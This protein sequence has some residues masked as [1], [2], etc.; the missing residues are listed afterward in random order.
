MATSIADLDLRQARAAE[1]TRLAI[2]PTIYRAPK[3]EFPKTAAET[4]GETAGETRVLGGVLGKLL[5]RLPKSA[6]SLLVKGRG[7][8][9]SSSPSTPPS[10]RVSPAVSPAVSAAVL[11]NSGLGRGN[12]NTRR[13]KPQE[14]TLGTVGISVRATEPKSPNTPSRPKFLQKTSLL[15]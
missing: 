9:R 4:A 1:G 11:G 3:P 2:P 5:R 6:V 15:K 12:G 8:L 10:T 7:S 14:Q 13:R